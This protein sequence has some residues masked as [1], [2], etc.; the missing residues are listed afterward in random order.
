MS[1]PQLQGDY[2]ARTF[3]VNFSQRIPLSS[4]Y[5]WDD[6][7][8]ADAYEG[9]FGIGELTNNVATPAYNELQLLTRSLKGETFTSK[10]NDGHTS[11]WLLV[12]TSPSGHQTLAAWTT[13][14]GGRTVTV[15]GWGT[16][17]S[18]V[19]ALLREPLNDSRARNVCAA[20]CRRDRI[21]RLR[22]EDAAA[23]KCG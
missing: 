7:P 5:E 15:S 4:W 14:S 6:D 17:Q 18:H 23:L 11:D 3:L 21:A 22:L 16:L 12:F 9:N 2:L 1:T 8:D 10:L 19:H 13:R 20:S